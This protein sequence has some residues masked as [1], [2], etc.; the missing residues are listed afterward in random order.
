MTKFEFLSV[1][2][3]IVLAFGI[4][5]ILSHWGAQIRRRHEIRHYPLHFAWTVLLL[6]L[7]IQ[8]WWS[9]W[10]ISEKET[11]TFLEFFSLIFPFLVISLVAYVLTPS[12]SSGDLDLKK[13]Y[14]AHTRWLF[15]LTAVYLVAAVNYTYTIVGESLLLPRNLIRVGAFLL[16]VALAVS[17]NETLHKL[18]VILAYVHAARVGGIDSFFAVVSAPPT[19]G[20]L[21]FQRFRNDS[22]LPSLADF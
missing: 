21:Q 13:H 22:D 18:A 8:L 12:F 15:G 11:W 1:F 16:V 19:G 5:D 20:E 3:S 9:S 14:F 2:I 6:L 7:M 4:S 17:K 10:L